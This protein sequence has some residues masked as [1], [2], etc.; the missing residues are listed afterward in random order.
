MIHFED[1][2]TDCGGPKHSWKQKI[3][4]RNHNFSE[5]LAPNKFADKSNRMRRG[6]QKNRAERGLFFAV[7]PAI[8]W[9]RDISSASEKTFPGFWGYLLNSLQKRGVLVHSNSL[10]S[11]LY[12]HAPWVV[13]SRIW[14]TFCQTSSGLGTGQRTFLLMARQQSHTNVKGLGPCWRRPQGHYFSVTKTL[15]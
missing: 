6:F 15:S 1:L 5:S 8:F 11:K 14:K 7:P 2:N 12:Y 10:T 9:K 13:I 3:Q 4:W